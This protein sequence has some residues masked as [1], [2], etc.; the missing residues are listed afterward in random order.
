MIA[1]I[2]GTLRT[3]VL[4]PIRLLLLPFK[5]VSFV[6]SLIFYLVVLAVLAGI[7]FLLVL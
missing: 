6:V 7:V 1:G 2:F 3:L 4:L 5:L